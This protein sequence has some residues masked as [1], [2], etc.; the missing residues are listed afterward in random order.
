MTETGNSREEK[1]SNPIKVLNTIMAETR[2]WNPII[3]LR[4]IVLMHFIS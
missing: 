4:L 2:G 3:I 1:K